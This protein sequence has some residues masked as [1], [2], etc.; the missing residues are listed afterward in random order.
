MLAIGRRRARTW[1]SGGSERGDVQALDLP[2]RAS[3]RDCTLGFC[4]IPTLGRRRSRGVPRVCAMAVQLLLLEHVA[5][6]PIVRAGRGRWSRLAV[7]SSRPSA[8]DPL[9]YMPSV[10]FEIDEVQR[11]KWGHRR[12]DYARTS[13]G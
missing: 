12:A 6:G 13:L 11:S 4:T 10:G 1:P 3:T 9:D 5:A 7:R 2:T 8:L